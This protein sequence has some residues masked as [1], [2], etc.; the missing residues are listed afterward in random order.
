MVGK[1]NL[2]GDLLWLK[3]YP[4]SPQTMTSEMVMTDEGN[5]LL[6]G[7]LDEPD[8]YDINVLLLDEN[9]NILHSSQ[10]TPR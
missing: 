2:D 8:S 10:L 9:G 3:T 7:K 1:L 4:G 6:V 5:L